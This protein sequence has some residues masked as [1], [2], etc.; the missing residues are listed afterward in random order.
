MLLS[1]VAAA[2]VAAAFVAVIVC[3]NCNCKWIKSKKPTKVCK[4]QTHPQDTPSNVEEQ[5]RAPHTV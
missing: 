1:V 5:H 3:E 2:T 4:Q